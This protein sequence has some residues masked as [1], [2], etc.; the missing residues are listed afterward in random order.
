MRNKENAN[1]SK[2]K[3]P[4]FQNY[5]LLKKLSYLSLGNFP[6]PIEKLEILGR[7]LGLNN[8]YIK[9]D[10]LS[11][12]I[13]GGNKVRKLEFLLAQALHKK[14][15]TVLT[16]GCAGSNHCLATAI[17]AKQLG[18]K[19]IA[20]LIPQPNAEYVRKNL[21][22]MAMAGIE[23]YY[24]KDSREVK[25]NLPW[26]VTKKFLT[27][28]RLPYIIPP[29]GSDI[30]GTAGFVNAALEL[31]EQVIKG[32]MPEPDYI[33]VSTGTM[34][35]ATGLALGL[36]AAG[37]R[38]KIM[39]VRVIGEE[40]FNWEK[41][42]KLFRLTNYYLRKLDWSFPLFELK[43]NDVQIRDS[44]YGGQYAQFTK[45]GMTALQ[46]MSELENIP[47]EGTY[48]GKTLAAVIQDS[49]SVTIKN[50]VIL[51]WNTYNS[52]YLPTNGISS[53]GLLE[54]LQRDYFYKKYRY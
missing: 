21:L 8:F 36:K 53:N 22:G 27:S 51:F 25:K 6:T 28:G 9:R 50:K 34:G 2:D 47:L 3:L 32:E 19:S 41:M 1:E 30:L 40:F 49:K 39:A 20:M 4:L 42:K 13:Y 46:I 48:T 24:C 43:E 5:P 54:G 11:G 45:E 16:F 52:R 37:L 23:L 7:R 38:T 15:K 12:K 33:Y 31:K 44:F 17:Y 14:A 18:L 10:D 26:Q 35:T 29:G